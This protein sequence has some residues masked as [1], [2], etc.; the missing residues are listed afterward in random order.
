[1]E[2]PGGSH[3]AG[4][5]E[6]LRRRVE[7]F[8]ARESFRRSIERGMTGSAGDQNLSI[9]RQ[10]CCVSVARA[11]HVPGRTKTPRLRLQGGAAAYQ[12]R[13]QLVQLHGLILRVS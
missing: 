7:K 2:G 11:A 5:S 3:A 10:R 9:V 6:R 8:G 13:G 1:M 12:Q 4:E